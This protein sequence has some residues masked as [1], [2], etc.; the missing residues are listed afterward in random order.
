M[1]IDPEFLA[2]GQRLQ[3]PSMDV[4]TQID[5]V[6]A[7]HRSEQ[8]ELRIGEAV[9]SLHEAV[10]SWHESSQSLKEQLFKYGRDRPD[11]RDEVT[12]R[13][14]GIAMLDIA[15]AAD[16]GFVTAL[17]EAQRRRTRLTGRRHLV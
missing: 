2:A 11:D 5:H 16:L 1:A 17:D 12:A 10:V 3:G 9:S 8:S 6:L 13:I 7:A 4:E 15:I 14:A